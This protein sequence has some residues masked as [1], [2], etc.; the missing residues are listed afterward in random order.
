[1]DKVT[2]LIPHSIP[3]SISSNFYFSQELEYKNCI[4]LSACCY[5]CTSVHNVSNKSTQDNQLCPQIEPDVGW[6]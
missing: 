5:S 2:A 3:L 1:M 4:D 6:F